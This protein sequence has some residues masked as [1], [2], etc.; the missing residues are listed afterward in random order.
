MCVTSEVRS[1]ISSSPQKL[2]NLKNIET[3]KFFDEVIEYLK[4]SGKN[5]EKVQK[6]GKSQ[7]IFVCKYQ[8]SGMHKIPTSDQNFREKCIFE[9]MRYW[10]LNK[11]DY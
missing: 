6:S 5:V 10:L 7:V 1:C 2:E 9:L 8:Y 4:N 11:I 3:G